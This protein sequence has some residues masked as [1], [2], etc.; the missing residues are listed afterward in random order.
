MVMIQCLRKDSSAMPQLQIKYVSM[1]SFRM[2]CYYTTLHYTKPTGPVPLLLHY[3]N[4]FTASTEL[5]QSPSILLSLPPTYVTSC[6]SVMKRGNYPRPSSVMSENKK[7]ACRAVGSLAAFGTYIK[8]NMLRKGRFPESNNTLD[9][10]LCTTQQAV[11]SQA[12]MR[13]PSEST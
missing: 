1:Y 13:F 12:A 2:V 9:H 3:G 8:A 7:Q 6:I 4:P 11:A 5:D 10:A